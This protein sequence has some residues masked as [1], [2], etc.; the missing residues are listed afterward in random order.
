MSSNRDY[1][2][3]ANHLK[4]AACVAE[5]SKALDSSSNVRKYARVQISPHALLLRLRR[6]GK[7]SGERGRGSLKDF[8]GEKLDF[9]AF[10]LIG[11]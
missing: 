4:Q 1:I 10:L 2:S 5:R 9:L 8:A 3:L 7:Y 11:V 6:R